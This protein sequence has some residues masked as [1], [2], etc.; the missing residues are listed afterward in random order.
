MDSPRVKG[1][2]NIDNGRYENVAVGVLLTAIRVAL[3][4]S[5]AGAPA[6]GDFR[7]R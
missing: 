7:A 6:K 2:I 4:L 1:G 5:D 3:S